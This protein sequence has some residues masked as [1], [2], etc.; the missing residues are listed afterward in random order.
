MA[1]EVKMRSLGKMKSVDVLQVKVKPGDVVVKNQPLLEIE[2]DK[3]TAD[4]PSPFAGKITDLW[5]PV[6]GQAQ[7]QF[8]VIGT[9][10]GK[11]GIE[12]CVV[13]YLLQGGPVLAGVTGPF[14]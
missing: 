8:P 3:G 2:S 14:D 11:G 6:G 4:F 7:M 5:V 10:N 9:A 1:T 12:T 13:A